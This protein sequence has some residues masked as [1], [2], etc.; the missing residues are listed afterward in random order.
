[1][2]YSAPHYHVVSKRISGGFFSPVVNYLRA[3]LIESVYRRLGEYF[4]S[5][6]IRLVYIR[7]SDHI[8]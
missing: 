4:L 2:I 5:Y 8:P 6:C 7:I 3:T 1:M